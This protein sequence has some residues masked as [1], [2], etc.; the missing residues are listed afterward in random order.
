M[1]HELKTSC[2]VRFSLLPMYPVQPCKKRKMRPSPCLPSDSIVV[3]ISPCIAGHHPYHHQ[4]G[5]GVQSVLTWF[6]S[7]W[8]ACGVRFF[9]VLF[10]SCVGGGSLLRTP[11][12]RGEETSLTRLRATAVGRCLVPVFLRHFRC[13]WYCFDACLRNLSCITLSFRRDASGCDLECSP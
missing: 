2:R 8:A 1:R 7:W 10:L 13:R 11:L 6:P 5:V 12:L 9:F 4:E 3:Y